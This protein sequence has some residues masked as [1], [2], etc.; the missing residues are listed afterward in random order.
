MGTP[1]YMSPEQC[2]GRA[3]VDH[4]T[5]IYALGIVLYEMLTGR[6][7]FIGEGYGEILVQH[8]T[9]HPAPPSQFQMLDPRVE[10]V[11]LKALEKRP[12]LRYPTMDEFS[13]AMT[14]PFGYV[15]AYG[16]PSEF[17]QRQLMP[18]NAPMPA[19]TSASGL[20][21]APGTLTPP[22]GIYPP[23]HAVQPPTTLGASAG[24]VTEKKKSKAGF[25]IAAAA[26]LAAAGGGIAVVLSR[27]GG[28]ETTQVASG[29]EQPPVPTPGSGS[30]MTV[31]HGSAGSAG[32]AVVP[33]TGSAGSAGSAAIPDTGS[34]GSAAPNTGSAGSAAVVVAPKSVL[35]FE[36]VPANASIFIDG[37]DTG[38]RT[39]EPVEVD[40][41]KGAVRID[42]KLDGY[43][44]YTR[45]NFYVGKTITMRVPLAKKS[46][47]HGPKSG[48]NKG[49]GK[50]NGTT[51]TGNGGVWQKDGLERPD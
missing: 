14:D 39:P 41:A 49:T 22:S 46:S 50:T 2:E 8:L 26:I 32:S 18:S 31:E 11:V 20:T 48:G 33:D 37:E 6:V 40:P 16:G 30:E 17:L 19:R 38:K 42:L 13:R 5:D 45:K 34:A 28:A 43:T 36:T 29:S 51:N 3:N 21:P 44:T 1:A 12:E 47:G 4:R 7:P 25:F 24:Q 9:Q 23:G 15:A 10:V 27:G 35:T